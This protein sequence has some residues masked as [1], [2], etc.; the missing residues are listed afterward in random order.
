MTSTAMTNTAITDTA[1]SASDPHPRRAR[2]LD[3]EISY[4]EVGRAPDVFLHGNP[5]SP[6]LWRNVIPYVA[7]PTLPRA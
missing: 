7:D 6:Y 1:I 3:T 5:T 4:V 2:I